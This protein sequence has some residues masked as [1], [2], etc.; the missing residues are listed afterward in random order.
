M[1]NWYAN[2]IPLVFV[3]L[4]H[5]F[6][7]NAQSIHLNGTVIDKVTGDP[8]GYAHVRAGDIITYSNENGQFNIRVPQGNTEKLEIFHM[9]YDIF[10]GNIQTEK[11]YLVALKPVEPTHSIEGLN[12]EEIMREVFNRFHLNYE[13]HDQFMLSY[14]RE[15]LND[16]DQIHYMGEGILELMLSSDV[17][18]SPSYVRPIKMRVKTLNNIIHK[19]VDSKSGHATEMIE[20]SIWHDKSFLREKNRDN[21]SYQLVGTEVH[22]NENIYILDF[23]PK[24]KKGY[25]AG[26]IFVDGYT[27][28]IIR[29]E[30]TLFDNLVFD[31]ET[32]IEEF[33]HHDLI[34]YLLRASFEG[35]WEEN[36]K[37]YVFR[38][39]IVNTEIE[40]NRDNTD[41][42]GFI[43]GNTFA[44]PIQSQGQFTDEFWGDYNY[45]Q[46]TDAEKSALK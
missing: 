10:F 39:M 37:K 24:N 7:S 1:K 22:R 36:G 30:Y 6:Q 38:S 35:V 43:I 14:Y 11:P 32:W 31:T 8:I 25:L 46:L 34:Y 42:N 19:G 28:A 29:L 41:M 16:D 44:F 27:Y 33:Q 4:I 26:K 40:P 45:I 12:G 18:E 20:S 21:Y 5:C 23:A 3:T 15:E 2:V 13:I 17:G 9:G